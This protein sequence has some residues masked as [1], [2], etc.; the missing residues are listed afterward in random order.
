MG[1]K[2]R[3]QSQEP[4]PSYSRSAMS[5][6]ILVVRRAGTYALPRVTSTAIAVAA[7]NETGSAGLVSY[8]SDTSSREAASASRMPA[9]IPAL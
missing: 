9:T 5:G 4:P 2:P 7:A 1:F 3:A 8:S 6:S